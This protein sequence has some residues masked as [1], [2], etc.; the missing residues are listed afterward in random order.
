LAETNVSSRDSHE[1]EPRKQ[2]KGVELN[3]A[4]KWIG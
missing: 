4:L 2:K 3:D 1:I